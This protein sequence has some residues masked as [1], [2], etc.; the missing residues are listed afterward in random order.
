M[1]KFFILASRFHPITV[2][3]MHVKIKRKVQTIPVHSTAAIS[4]QLRSKL[5]QHF[6]LNAQIPKRKL[7]NYV[8]SCTIITSKIF[9]SI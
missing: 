5:W 9:I 8:Y 2:L 1:F 4:T 6:H 7:E 3:P